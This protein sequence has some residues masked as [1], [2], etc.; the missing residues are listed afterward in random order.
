MMV[1]LFTDSKNDELIEIFLGADRA[2]KLRVYDILV[3]I[4]PYRA[5]KFAVLK[6]N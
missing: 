1:Q 2:E 4:D 3:S 5:S 6:Q